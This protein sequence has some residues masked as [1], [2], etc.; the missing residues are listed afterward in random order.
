MSLF[1]YYEYVFPMSS[2]LLSYEHVFSFTKNELTRNVC[3]CRGLLL[4]G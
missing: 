1:I 3:N 2:V 4:R